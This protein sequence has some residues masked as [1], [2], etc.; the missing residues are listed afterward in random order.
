MIIKKAQHNFV[1]VFNE[2]AV[3]WEEGH[4]R[5]KI[6]RKP[7]QQPRAYYVEGRQ[8]DKIDYIRIVKEITK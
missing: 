4:T 5:V 6:V 2:N 7:G 8:L 1:D 3:G